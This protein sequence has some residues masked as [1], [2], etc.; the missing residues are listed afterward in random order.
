MVLS[1][2]A[3]AYS[4]D[5]RKS[6]LEPPQLM[7]G[8]AASLVTAVQVGPGGR[9]CGGLRGCRWGLL[10]RAW[11][12]A[13]SGAGVGRWAQAALL[14]TAGQV[15]HGGGRCGGRGKGA[16]GVQCRR[17]L[18]AGFVGSDFGGSGS[19]GASGAGAE[20]CAGGAWGQCEGR[21]RERCVSGCVLG[22]V[23]K[24]FWTTACLAVPAGRGLG[25]MSG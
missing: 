9:R 6:M 7:V 18:G 2:P 24:A 10:G 15:G 23:G 4:H 21:G 22:W 16:K 12:V 1:A 13:S 19:W 3:T 20:A 17:G 11:C 5:T 25:E 14:V 8:A